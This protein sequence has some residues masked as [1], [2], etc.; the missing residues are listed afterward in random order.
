MAYENKPGQGVMFPR[1]KQGNP[2]RPDYSG[3]INVAGHDY[4]ISAWEKVARSGGRYISVEV[5]E[6]YQAQRPQGGYQ[7]PQ[8]A[9]QQAPLHN[10]GA[11]P[12]AKASTTARKARKSKVT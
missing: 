6:P 2:N 5:R 3:T 1:D 9:P 4:D 10:E 11:Q 8:Q 7:Q 12:K